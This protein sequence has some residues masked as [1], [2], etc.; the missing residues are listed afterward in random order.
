MSD[1]RTR[2]REGLVA[3]AVAGVASGVPSTIHAIAAG[4]PP[5]QATRAA[6]AILAPNGGDRARLVAAVPVHAALSLG[7]G[8]VLSFALPRRSPAWWGAVAGAGIAAL[9]LGVF[10][11]RWPEITA[12]PTLPQVADHIA[13]GAGVGA[14]LDRRRR[15]PARSRGR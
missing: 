13:F 4:R 5:L 3:G 6:G 14:V 9:D 10:G 1:A 2:L 11:R 12:L 7:W 8:V 15:S